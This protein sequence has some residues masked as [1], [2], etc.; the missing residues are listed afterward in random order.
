MRVQSSQNRDGNKVLIMTSSGNARNERA[1]DPADRLRDLPATWKDGSSMLP[2]SSF[3]KKASKAR[4]STRSPR[5]APAS[6]PTIYGHFPG[7]EALFAAVVCR[8]SSTDW[9]ISTAT[10]PKDVRCRISSRASRPRLPREPLTTRSIVMRATI[11][12]AQRFPDLSRDVHEASRS[13][14]ADAV[15]YLLNDAIRDSFALVKGTFRRTKRILSTAQI[16]MDL[17]LLPMLMR[18]LMGDEPKSLRKELPSFARERV[19]FFWRPARGIGCID[20]ASWRPLA[21][22]APAPALAVLI[23]TRRDGTDENSIEPVLAFL[24][25]LKPLSHLELC[26]A[27]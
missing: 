27:R 21:I 19:S 16:F 22:S 11:A 13:R 6:K 2:R 24:Q 8:A 10:Y 17:I 4:A 15:S 5:L 3:S 1:C 7:K 14:A 20:D 18:S 25:C 12:E 23:A 26:L 9:R